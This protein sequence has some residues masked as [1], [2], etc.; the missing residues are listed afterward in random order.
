MGSGYFQDLVTLCDKIQSVSSYNQKTQ[1]C[2]EFFTNFS[3]DLYLLIKLLLC[4]QDQRVYHIRDKQLAKV[5][6]KIFKSDV[7]E[8]VKD[9]EENGDHAETAAKVTTH[10]SYILLY[11]RIITLVMTTLYLCTIVSS[12]PP[13]EWH[14]SSPT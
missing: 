1:I 10:L 3:G 13:A 5:L 14:R 11:S 9:L 12:L 6:S 2:K 8:M 7:E 4:K